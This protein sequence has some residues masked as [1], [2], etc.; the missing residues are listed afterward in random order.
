MIKRKKTV[1][2]GCVAD[3]DPVLSGPLDTGRFFCR[4]LDLG[5]PP[6]ISESLV[7]IFWVKIFVNW[8]NFLRTC[9][10][11]PGSGINIKDPQHCS[12][13]VP[14]TV[15]G[16]SIPSPPPPTPPPT[17]TARMATILPSLFVTSMCSRVQ[18]HRY[19]TL[20]FSILLVNIKKKMHACLERNPPMRMVSTLIPVI[21][22]IQN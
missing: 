5:A 16:L 17:N 15:T 22:I 6:H 14:Y 19:R 18:A 1:L 11:D 21:V 9:S 8:L 13:R 3:P 4:I 7:K 2:V 12:W 20:P 10:L